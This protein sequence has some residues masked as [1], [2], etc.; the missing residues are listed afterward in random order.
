MAKIYVLFIKERQKSKIINKKKPHFSASVT[1][2]ILST[3]DILTQS[4]KQ[5]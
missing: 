3:T 4:S 1:A 2:N 5:P